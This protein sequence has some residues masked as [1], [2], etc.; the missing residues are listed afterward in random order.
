MKKYTFF[1]ACIIL[2]FCTS[3]KDIG[4]LVDQ[5]KSRSYFIDSKGK[6]LYS[7]SGDWFTSG[8]SPMNADA[9]SFQVL[10][11]DLAKDKDSVYYCGKAQ[12]LVVDIPSFHLK[13]NIMKDRFHVFYN[14][15]GSIYSITGADPKTYEL[16]NNH[17][18][19]TRDKDHYFYDGTMVSADRKTFAF[20]NDYF[21][22]DKD[23]VYVLYNTRHFKSVLPNKANIESINKYYIKAGNTIYF[24]PFGKDSNAVAKTFNSL[25]NIRIINPSIISINNKTILSSG[26]NF[27]YDQVDA[28]SFQLFPADEDKYTYEISSYSK[29]KN[30]VYYDEEVIPAA[31]TKTFIIMGDYFGKDAKNAYYKNQLL[32]GVDAQSFKKEGD[33]YKDKSGNKFNAIGGNKI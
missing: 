8:V 7:S 5:K 15:S 24:P 9:K 20:V 2:S 30:N 16:I 28:G 11:E 4:K 1:L 19:W 21:H 23:S 29:D 22:K 12:D 3:C 31:D 26:K 25:D 6:I 27:K 33:F 14:F 17:K 13:N 32:K 18:E 10:A